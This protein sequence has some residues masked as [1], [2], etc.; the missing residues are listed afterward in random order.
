MS[1][2]ETENQKPTRERLL[3]AGDDV[4]EFVSDTGRRSLR[5]KDSPL[6]RLAFGNKPKITGALYNAGVKFYED[7]Y[8]AGNVSSG[9]IDPAKERVDGGHFMNISDAVVAA[10]VRHEHTIKSLD[11]ALYM[12]LHLVVIQEVSFADF[13]KRFALHTTS[14]GKHEAAIA[15]IR[16]AL[17]ALDRHYNPPRRGGGIA[18]SHAG[19][20]RPVIHPV[21]R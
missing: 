6:D 7:A 8:L 9:V 15:I 14:R 16:L 18:S 12:T 11:Y 3:K 2:D 10:M 4:L 1:I 19:D 5:M 20:Y 13:A 21:K 17:D